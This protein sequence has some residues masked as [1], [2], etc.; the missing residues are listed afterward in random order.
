M[1][2]RNPVDGY[3][4]EGFSSREELLGE[5]EAESITNPEDPSEI[6]RRLAGQ[7]RSGDGPKPEDLLPHSS[8]IFDATFLA[9]LGRIAIYVLDSREAGGQLFARALYSA[10]QAVEAGRADDEPLIAWLATQTLLDGDATIAVDDLEELLPGGGRESV[11]R[12]VIAERL[13]PA[14]ERGTYSMPDSWAPAEAS[15]AADAIATT[16]LATSFDHAGAQ[17]WAD[18]GSCRL[19][20]VADVRGDRPSAADSKMQQ[21]ALGSYRA[22]TRNVEQFEDA[23]S[24]YAAISAIRAE[25][26]LASSM[27]SRER[28]LHAAFEQFDALAAA[29]RRKG[30]AAGVRKAFYSFAQGQA[31]HG[32][33]PKGRD[34]DVLF[35]ASELEQ[36]SKPRS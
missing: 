31:E 5:L 1:T 29:E 26:R 8:S 32:G 15:L 6:G 36:A 13:A 16:G 23:H 35:L 24:Q 2:P 17:A 11:A 25:F 21:S 34:D 10:Q 7:V 30:S 19:Q 22:I 12:L 14:A 3:V 27:E 20:E 9:I 28:A 18:L 4:V 33:L